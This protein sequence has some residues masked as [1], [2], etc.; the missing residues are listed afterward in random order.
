MDRYLLETIEFDGDADPTDYR[1]RVIHI[2]DFE[3]KETIWKHVTDSHFI[4]KV[5]YSS[6]AFSYQ[7]NI[8]V[9]NLRDLSRP[10]I[11]IRTIGLLIDSWMQFGTS[12]ELDD[13]DS[14]DL[15]YASRWFAFTNEQN[16][17]LYLPNGAILFLETNTIMMG[18]FGKRIQEMKKSCDCFFG[19]QGEDP[20]RGVVV[21][22]FDFEF[23]H[24]IHPID[25]VKRKTKP[26]E[27]KKETVPLDLESKNDVTEKKS[28]D[29][30]FSFQFTSDVPTDPIKEKRRKN[31]EKQ[32]KKQKILKNARIWMSLFPLIL[33]KF[34]CPTLSRHLLGFKLVCNG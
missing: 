26:K 6:F 30:D 23:Q 31:S 17:I 10:R 9:Y 11:V 33:N 13:E 8:H 14:F 3:R 22:G 27:L 12:V 24:P 4:C 21:N 1:R 5:S 16:L 20:V 28:F 2:W 34:S 7:G 19:F 15:K 25:K 18:D 29:F 32:P